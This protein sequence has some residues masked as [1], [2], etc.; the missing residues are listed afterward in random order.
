MIYPHRSQYLHYDINGTYPNRTLHIVAYKSHYS[1]ATF[2]YEFQ[3]IFYENA[4]GIVSITYF[5][6]TDNGAT[7]TIGIQRKSFIHLS[8]MID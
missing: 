7:A 1:N 5:Q 4:P 8:V 6:A 2:F 3:V